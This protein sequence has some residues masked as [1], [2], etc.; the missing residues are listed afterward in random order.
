MRVPSFDGVELD[1]WVL[2]PDVPEGVRVPVVLWSAPYF[3]QCDWLVGPPPECLYG[4]GDDP[5]LRTSGRGPEIVPIDLLVE[6]GYAVA[7]FNV[8]G[9]G[10][11]GG[12]LDWHGPDEQRDQVEL[13]EWLA[14]QSWTSGRVGMQ[15]FSYHGTTPW[16]AAIQ[17]PEALKTIVVGGMATDP[18]TWH[19]T[20]QGASLTRSYAAPRFAL[21]V[22]LLPPTNAP[23]T[24]W[25]VDHVPVVAERICPEVVRAMADNSMGVAADRRDAAFWDDRRVIDRFPNV[26]AAVFLAHGFLDGANEQQALWI[27]THLA[28]AP[29]RMVEG[30]WGHDMPGS[31]SIDPALRVHDWDQT[32]LAWYDFWLKGIGN[33]PPREGLADYQDSTGAWHESAGWPPAEAR[34]ELLY[35]A[36][37]RRLATLPGSGSASFRSTPDV[38]DADGDL[39]GDPPWQTAFCPGPLETVLGR[40]DRLAAAYVSE[41]AAQDLLIA[42]NPF[43]YLR[44]SSDLPGGF[45][46]V[47]VYDMAPNAGCD[48]GFERWLFG[49]ADLRFHQGNFEGR[50]FPTDAPT[51]VRIDLNNLAGILPEGH[52]LAVVVSYG[53]GAFL[54][55][56]LYPNRVPTFGLQ[57][58]ITIHH[59]GGAEAS[60]V[61]L[62]LVEGT[63]GGA[64]PTLDYPPRPFLPE[65]R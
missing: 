16:E 21:R 22:S 2:R 39:D 13:V 58:R 17:N 43:A 8:R 31:L 23:L 27:W 51:H 14:V 40:G 32:L 19:Y 61:V 53:G 9:T 20:P 42:G 65:V 28:R 18:Y 36:D 60:H 54:G 33:R 62:P 44:L 59:D 49:A 57:P 25:T 55:A 47:H 50:D 52:R 30:Q 7:V 35:L 56:P 48:G 34:T 3:G 15:G 5:A 4:T 12:C 37:A 63:L 46:A 6:N 64:P 38:Q 26:D 24:H 11:S 41:P 45:V 10:N 29:K 1:G